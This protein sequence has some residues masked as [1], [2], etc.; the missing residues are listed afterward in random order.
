[1]NEWKSNDAHGN[2]ISGFSDTSIVIVRCS[3]TDLR[4]NF[5]I[6]YIQE[7]DSLTRYKV[8]MYKRKEIKM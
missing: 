8:Y 3:V 7:N 2:T 4:V 5:Q 1:M 6:E